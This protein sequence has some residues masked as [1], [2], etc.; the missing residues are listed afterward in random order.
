MGLLGGDSGFGAAQDAN[1]RIRAMYEQ[2][3][4]PDYKEMVPELYNTESANYQLNTEDPVVKSMQLQALQKMAGLA[5]TGMSDV[6][7]AGYQNAKNIGLQQAHGGTAATIQ[8]MQNRGIAGSGQELAMREIA[9]Q[10]GAQASQQAALA[11]ASDAAKQRAL[12][13]QAYGTQL[14]GVRSQNNQT[15]QANTDIINR[16]NQANTNQANQTSAANVDQRNSAFKYN[17]GLKDKNYENQLGMADRMSGVYNRNG[18]I[19][20]A[21]AEADRKKRQAIGGAIGTGAGAAIGGPVGAGVGGA[22]GSGLA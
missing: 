20:A 11:Q 16:F 18:E 5:D 3:Q 7:A 19:G 8:D 10:G 6:D 13:A 4:N 22:I 1:D 12:Y 21:E 17:E 2:I 9:N 15:G 14:A